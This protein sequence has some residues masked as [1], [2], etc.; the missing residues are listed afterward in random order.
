MAGVLEYRV[1]MN[2]S[3]TGASGFLSQKLAYGLLSANELTDKAG[4]P[5]RVEHL[6]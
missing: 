6:T 4:S 2:I 5:S 1:M 3:I